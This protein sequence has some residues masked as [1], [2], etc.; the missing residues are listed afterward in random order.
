MTNSIFN[1]ENKIVVVTGGLGQL[2][3]EFAKTLLENKARV[4]ILDM[5]VSEMLLPSLLQDYENN[6]QLMLIKADVTSR[7][8]LEQALKKI[9]KTWGKS[10]FGLINNAALDSPPSAPVDETGPFEDFP[11]AS[12]DRVMDVNVKGSFQACQ[13]FGKAMADMGTGSII[14]IGSTYGVVSPDQRIYEYQEINSGKQ[15]YKPVVYS[16]S[17]SALVNLTKYIAV[18]WAKSGVR[19]NLMALGGVF[20]NQDEEFIKGYCDKVPMGR[21]ANA[22]EY[23]GTVV[24]LMSDASSYV[25]GATIMLDGGWTAW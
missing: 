16:A 10:P 21:M 1:I 22:D 23:N 17:K 11:S 13:V 20:N 5:S 19:T 25:T 15:F 14:N 18:Y 9:Q 24:Y 7:K 4:V 8:S 6:S 3:Q 2:G 12:W